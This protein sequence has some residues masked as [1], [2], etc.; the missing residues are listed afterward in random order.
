MVP[1]SQSPH[2]IFDPCTVKCTVGTAV[3][4]SNP[5]QKTRGLTALGVTAP[6]IWEPNNN[7]AV[8]PG[9]TAGISEVTICECSNNAGQQPHQGMIT[10]FSIPLN[11]S[12]VI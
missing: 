4:G 10:A 6:R 3:P 7:P 8:R 11:N 5:P 1:C 9:D 2:W 12:H